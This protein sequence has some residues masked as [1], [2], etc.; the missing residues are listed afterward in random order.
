M[1]SKKHIIVLKSKIYHKIKNICH[2]ICHVESQITYYYVKGEKT[3]TKENK[4]FTVRLFV[5]LILVAVMVGTSELTGERE[6][7]FPEIAALS[8]GA[9]AAPK[10][11]WITDRFRMVFLIFICSVIGILIV[12]SSPFA[13]PIN[14]IAAFLICQMLYL[15]SGTSFAPMISAA[16]LPVLMNTSSIIYPISAVTMTLL[17]VLA[18]YLLEHVG[19]YKREK[20][21]TKPKPAVY[22]WLCLSVR[23]AVAALIVFPSTRFGLNFCVAPPLLVAFTEFSN[24]ESKAR[25]NPIKTVLIIVCCAFVGAMLRYLLCA[26]AGFPLISAAVLSTAFSIIVMHL[27]GQYI[28]PAGALGILPMIIPSESLLIYPAEIAAGATAFMLA[29]V[30]FRKKDNENA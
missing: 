13:K 8:I 22:D 4:N 12:R 29:S 27:A 6:V 24:P 7:I 15:C 28:P 5:C 23:T 18:Q 30:C 3:V 10:Q 26:L 16:V 25:K 2:E 1:C 19:I 20:F 9:V 21:V 17:T 14:I 11:C